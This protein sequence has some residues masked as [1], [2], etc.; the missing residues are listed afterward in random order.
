[1]AQRFW[2]VNS[3]VNA[4]EDKKLDDMNLEGAI[5]N[6]DTNPETKEEDKESNIFF[7]CCKPSLSIAKS[8]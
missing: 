1:M 2:R 7:T 4:W 8:I 3:E 6:D 5:E